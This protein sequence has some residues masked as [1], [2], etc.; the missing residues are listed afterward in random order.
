VRTYVN[1]IHTELKRLNVQSPA[2]SE[3]LDHIVRAV[4]KVLDL[5]RDLKEQLLRWGEAGDH[6]AITIH[7][8]ILLEEA[9]DVPSLP[10]PIQLIMQIDPDVASVKVVHN[11]VIDILH[12]LITNAIEVM[13]DGGTITLGA[14][15][16]GRWVAL[17]VSDQGSGIP[18][19]HLKKVFHLFYSTKRSTGFGLW[20]ARRN[21]L[22]NHG[23]LEV[24]TNADGGATFTLLLPNVEGETL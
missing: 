24:R 21:A 9:R 12:N 10:P 7:P 16:S 13:P 1:T 19:P 14:R 15:N 6:D 17:E 4:G 23:E 2:I 11:Q 3:K 20:S 8:R 22:S 18:E 5:S